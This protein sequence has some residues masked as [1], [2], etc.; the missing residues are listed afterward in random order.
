MKLNQNYIFAGILIILVL[1][2]SISFKQNRESFSDMERW[3][4]RPPCFDSVSQKYLKNPTTRNIV[5]PDPGSDL[6]KNWQYNPQSTLVDYKYYQDNRDLN[7]YTCNYDNQA[8]LPS[9]E[10]R[11]TSQLAPLTRSSLGITTFPTE[12]K[13]C[14]PDYIQST[15]IPNRQSSKK[16]IKYPGEPTTSPIFKGPSV[17][18]D[19]SNLLQS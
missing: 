17:T 3:G 15:R 10:N 5:G 11:S 4:Y 1:I 8:S 16:Y 7:Y 14:Q 13:V 2:G 9:G 6:I 19:Y 12:V 18:Y